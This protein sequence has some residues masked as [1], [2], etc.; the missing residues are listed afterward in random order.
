MEHV[1]FV[2]DFV[3]FFIRNARLTHSSAGSFEHIEILFNH[4]GHFKTESY[5]SMYI[6]RI[7][8]IYGFFE[9]NPL[10]RR[11]TFV[12]EALQA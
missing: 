8:L 3:V 9:K 5:S 1:H 6:R 12:L 10:K 11:Y 4:N 7:V 2:P